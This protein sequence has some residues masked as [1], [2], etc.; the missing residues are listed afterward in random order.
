M[1]L[2]QVLDPGDKS[3]AAR[4][5]R[6]AAEDGDLSEDLLQPVKI[7]G[8]EFDVFNGHTGRGS[9]VPAFVDIATNSLP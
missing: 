3:A 5:L 8:G 2:D 6:E 9:S 4:L 7:L 1:G